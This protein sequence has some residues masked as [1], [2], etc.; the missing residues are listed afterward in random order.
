MAIRS[1]WA[2]AIAAR[3]G[4]RRVESRWYRAEKKLG[5]RRPALTAARAT[6]IRVDRSHGLPAPVDAGWRLPPLSFRPGQ[7]RAQEARWSAVGK[8]DMSTPISARIC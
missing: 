8:R 5:W 3:L 2:T 1:E 6:S 7:T 4:P